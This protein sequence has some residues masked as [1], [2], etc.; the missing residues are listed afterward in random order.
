MPKRIKNQIFGRTKHKPNPNQTPKCTDFLRF[1][2]SKSRHVRTGH[3][4][5]KLI[6]YSNFGQ[7]QIFHT[8]QPHIHLRTM[9]DANPS[10]CKNPSQENGGSQCKRKGRKRGL[11]N[12]QNDKLIPIIER[13]LPNGSEA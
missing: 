9:S 12:Y 13:I 4:L 3:Y 10:E 1:F 8:S 6:F 11:P 5:T 7:N 2:L